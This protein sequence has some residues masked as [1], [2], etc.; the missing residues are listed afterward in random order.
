MVVFYR[1]HLQSGN[2]QVFHQLCQQLLAQGMNPLPL[3]LLS[4]KDA[5]SL[6]LLHQLCGAHQVS[7]I[8]NTTSFAQSSLETPGDHA[9]AGDIPVLQV[10]MSGSNQQ[11]WLDDA[12]G[13]S[14]ATL[15]CM[16]PCPRWTA[17]SSRAPSASKGCRTAAS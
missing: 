13:C 5:T 6:A 2:T 10:I 8:L 1:A 3:A 17:A 7:L 11:S 9:L 16:W 4:L 12:Q 14:R 15:P